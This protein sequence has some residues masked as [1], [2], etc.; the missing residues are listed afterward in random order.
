MPGLLQTT[1][2]STTA[3]YG[4]QKAA[5][6]ASENYQTNLSVPST[7]SRPSSRGSSRASSRDSSPVSAKRVGYMMLSE[8]L[9]HKN[10]NASRRVSSASSS[11]A[12]SRASSP[13]PTKRVGYMVIS[14]NLVHKSF[15]MKSAAAAEKRAS[16]DPIIGSVDNPTGLSVPS[17]KRR[18]SSKC[19]SR[20]S[21]RSSSPANTKREENKVE[22]E[23]L[24]L[25]TFGSTTHEE[26]SFVDPYD[27]LN[28]INVPVPTH[29]EQ[30][31]TPISTYVQ[32]TPVFHDESTYPTPVVHLGYGLPTNYF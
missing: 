26:V 23:E 24:A 29:I 4:N 9:A 3:S 13:V 8:D 1:S 27:F 15:G 31:N 20:G 22:S 11:R 18:S 2:K 25:Q 16:L 19:F 12:S 6:R 21:S 5:R 17:I 28:H 14:E 10:F 32:N 30:T 7:G